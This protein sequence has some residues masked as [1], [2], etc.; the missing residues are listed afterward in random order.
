[1]SE[2]KHLRLLR[3]FVLGA[4]LGGG[5]GSGLGLFLIDRSQRT[6]TGSSWPLRQVHAQLQLFGF[7]IPLVIGFA[8][9]LVPRLAGGRKVSKP[10]AAFVALGGLF[11]GLV[12][13]LVTPFATDAGRVLHVANGLCVGVACVS[14]AWALRG[15]LAEHADAIGGRS[16][17][18]YLWLFEG[19]ALFLALAGVADA[20][21]FFL[22]GNEALPFFPDNVARATW[23]LALDGFVVAMALGV[24]ARMFT[25]FLGIDPARAYPS[26][27][28]AYRRGPTAVLVFNALALTWFSSVVISAAGELASSAFVVHLGELLFALAIVPF[29]F[30]IGLAPKR[31]AIDQTQDPL[32]PYGARASYLLLVLA[33]LIGAVTAIAAA[34]GQTAFAMWIDVRRHFISIGF[35]MTLIATMA[36]R[37]APGYAQRPL[38]LP[39][40]RAFAIFAFVLSALMRAGEGIAGQ[41]ALAMPLRVSAY[42]GWLALAGFTALLVSLGATLVHARAVK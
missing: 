23:R 2:V 16:R 39:W 30:R 37:L 34:F 28:S 11:A 19:A 4:L 13:T 6:L 25:G 15:P 17:A 14:A 33:A 12:L 35:A 18:G 42:S 22:A 21:G 31:L 29:A 27:K 10:T 1:M 8:L 32:F 20:A 41:W 24:S 7:L 3:P 9:F 36:G 5:A 40:L 38:A 26:D